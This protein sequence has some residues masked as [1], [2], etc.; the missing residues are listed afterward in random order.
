MRRQS[1]FGMF[2]V[3]AV[4]VILAVLA[5]GLVA[6]S[7]TQSSN[8]AQDARAANAEQA[9]R[10][11]TEW[12]LFRAFNTAAPWCDNATAA[13]PVQANVNLSSGF[14]VAV[15]CWANVYREGQEVDPTVP[16]AV[17]PVLR[18]RVVRI[19]QVRAIACPAGGACPANGAVAAASNYVERRRE[20]VG[21]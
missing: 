8:L 13:A 21:F 17:P 14:Q 1:G 20:A 19:Y 7:S 6:L 12:G 15:T 16:A 18:N 9:A 2:A 4:L 5:G 3:I 11:G 10:A